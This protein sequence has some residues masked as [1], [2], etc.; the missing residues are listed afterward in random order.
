MFV[1]LK[2]PLRRPDKKDWRSISEQPGGKGDGQDDIFGDLQ[3]WRSNSNRND[4]T[5]G[6][7]G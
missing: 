2:E 1:G 5:R 7:Q 6:L 3:D 4:M